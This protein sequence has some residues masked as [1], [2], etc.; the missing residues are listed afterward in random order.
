[1]KNRS[2]LYALSY[3]QECDNPYIVFCNLIQ[4]VLYKSPNNELPEGELIKALTNEF[5]ITISRGIVKIAMG[6]LISNKNIEKKYAYR[7]VNCSMD[8]TDYSSYCSDYN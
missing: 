5:G 4:Y 3:I 2:A 1:M 6:I 7:L 8:I